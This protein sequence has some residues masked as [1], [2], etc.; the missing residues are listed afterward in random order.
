MKEKMVFDSWEEARRI[1]IE[2]KSLNT[3]KSLFFSKKI[4]F[5]GKKEVDL[6]DTE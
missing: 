5:L 3:E 2:G 1:E 4:N 6:T